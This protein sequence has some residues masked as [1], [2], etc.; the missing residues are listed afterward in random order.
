[1][2]A[3]GGG[4]T[5]QPRAL[6]ISPNRSAVWF[7]PTKA[8]RRAYIVISRNRTP[9]LGFK[10]IWTDLDT[11]EI[12]AA[13]GRAASGA[14]HDDRA[15]TGYKIFLHFQGS[16]HNGHSAKIFG[17][18]WDISNWHND[19]PGARLMR[20]LYQGYSIRDYTRSSSNASQGG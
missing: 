10:S 19:C 8:H 15:R 4:F 20:R 14:D 7:S 18:H 5:I 13:S 12:L 16:T 17:C 3:S 1:M 6:D 9:T 11:V 2:A